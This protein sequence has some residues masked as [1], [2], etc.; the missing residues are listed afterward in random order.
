MEVKMKED[1]W[2][3]VESEVWNPEEGQEISGVYLGVQNE[4]GENSSS[5]YSIET[6]L[7]RQTGIWGCKVLDGKMIGVKIGQEIKIKFI[8]RVKPEKGKE[9]KSFEVYT[10]PLKQ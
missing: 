7:G 10:K 4:I 6:S 2:T 5:L 8:G 3:K 1:N 9:Y